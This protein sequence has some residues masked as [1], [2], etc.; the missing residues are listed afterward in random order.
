MVKTQTTLNTYLSPKNNLK[1]TIEKRQKTKRVQR[2]YKKRYPCQHEDCEDSAIYGFTTDGVRVYCR[3]HGKNVQGMLSLKGKRCEKEKCFER[4]TW[5][6]ITIDGKGKKHRH[7][8]MCYIHRT[9]HMIDVN[10]SLCKDP[11]CLKTA[12][13]G[14]S[15][16]NGSKHLSMCGKHKT[17]NMQHLSGPICKIVGCNKSA[18]YGVIVFEKSKIVRKY[19]ACQYHKKENMR[20][21]SVKLCKHFENCNNTIDYSKDLCHECDPSIQNRAEY[22]FYTAMVQE[23][24]PLDSVINTQKTSTLTKRNG[25]TKSR[26]PDTMYLFEHQDHVFVYLLEFDEDAHKF[27]APLD[28]V[29]KLRDTV[30]YFE[31]KYPNKKIQVVCLRIKIPVVSKK[32]EEQAARTIKQIYQQQLQYPNVQQDKVNVKYMFYPPNSDN[33]KYARTCDD[34][35]VL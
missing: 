1:K 13:Y 33:V 3:K 30:L 5:G 14:Y 24:I 9:E 31:H 29:V 2:K 6:Y 10:K 28:E 35:N 21:L 19:Q 17:E 11:T 32:K 22:I 15:D 8:H 20:C 7:T 27:Y 34:V 18:N 23:K 16:E 4:A 26:K 25:M 12:T